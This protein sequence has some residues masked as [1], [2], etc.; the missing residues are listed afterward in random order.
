M[1]TLIC[2]HCGATE[3]VEELNTKKPVFFRHSPFEEECIKG[4]LGEW[5]EYGDF[6]N[7]YIY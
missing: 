6:I 5:V 1:K 7:L 4:E 2:G 3:T